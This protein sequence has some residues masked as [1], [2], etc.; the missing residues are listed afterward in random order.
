M[1]WPLS[2]L[3]PL[4]FL[5]WRHFF[6][7][8]DRLWDPLSFLSNGNWDLFQR[9]QSRHS[10]KLTYPPHTISRFRMWSSVFTPLICRDSTAAAIVVVIKKRNS[11][12]SLQWQVERSEFDSR[13]GQAFLSSP[14]SVIQMVTGNSF[15]KGKVARASSWPLIFIKCLG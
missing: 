6:P 3:T 1:L 10:A 11:S 15:S 7:R 5:L 2:H 9:R 8:T 14:R 4:P 13:P 12:Q